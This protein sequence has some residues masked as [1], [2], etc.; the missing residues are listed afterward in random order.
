VGELDIALDA[1]PRAAY[2][3]Q[4][5]YGVPIR[6]ALI[7]LILG[8]DRNHQLARYARGFPKAEHPVHDQPAGTGLSCVNP[9]CIV[10]DPYDGKYARN[11]FLLIGGASPRL[12]CFYCETD[13]ADFVSADRKTRHYERGPPRRTA[14]TTKEREIMFFAT[15]E[16]AEAEGFTPP[17]RRGRA[18]G[19]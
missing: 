13:I 7:A 8:L 9:N 17:K 3:R 6:M 1:D 14:A 5:A 2:F 4:A 12:R 16:A 15:P 10:H 19:G 18:A 11:Q